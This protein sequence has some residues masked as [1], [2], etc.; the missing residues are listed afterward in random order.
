QFFPGDV[1]DVGR[2]E[3]FVAEEVLNPCHAVAIELVRRLALG[4]C[5]SSNG[6]SGMGL[7]GIDVSSARYILIPG[8]VSGCKN[9]KKLMKGGW[10]RRQAWTARA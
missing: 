5:S 6:L 9:C 8:A 2:D 1:F 7:T 3:P 4:L 10:C